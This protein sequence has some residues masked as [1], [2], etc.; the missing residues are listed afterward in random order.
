MNE[1]GNS[2]QVLGQEA[3][4]GQ[5]QVGGEEVCVLEAQTLIK[6]AVE[7]HVGLIFNGSWV[8]ALQTSA[9]VARCLDGLGQ[10][11]FP[12]D[13]KVMAGGAEARK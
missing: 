4:N 10:V 8:G 1:R 2:N 9:L 11:A 12:F 7:N 6:W 5:R 3:W 13:A